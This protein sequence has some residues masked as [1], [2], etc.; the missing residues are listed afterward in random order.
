[1]KN[2]L[3]IA[4]SLQSVVNCMALVITDGK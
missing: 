3:S 1:V 2:D 4:V